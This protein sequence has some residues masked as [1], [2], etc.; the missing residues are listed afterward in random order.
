MG[1]ID[2]NG[3]GAVENLVDRHTR[4]QTRQRC[5]EAVVDTQP[6]RQMR[7]VGGGEIK[8]VSGTEPTRVTIGGA[9]EYDDAT[10]AGISTPAISVS[11]TATRDTRCSG[12]YVRNICSTS[13][14]TKIAIV[15]HTPIAEPGIRLERPLLNVRIEQAECRRTDHTKQ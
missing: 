14:P 12:A 10:A 2:A 8:P 4:L 9:Y 7:G 3:T 11:A 6:E 1:R 13:G 5:P 15:R